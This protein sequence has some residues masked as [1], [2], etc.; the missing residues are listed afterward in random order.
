MK[1]DDI[2]NDYP[3][4]TENYIRKGFDNLKYKLYSHLLL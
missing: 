3:L 2:I 4:L 1:I